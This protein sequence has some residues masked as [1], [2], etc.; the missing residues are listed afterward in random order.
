MFIAYQY[1]EDGIKILTN[2]LCEYGSQLCLDVSA[3]SHPAHTTLP[4]ATTC[5]VLAFVISAINQSLW[6]GVAIRSVFTH[7]VLRLSRE[8]DVYLYLC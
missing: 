1:I 2:N 5:A 7:P 3:V 4:H 8:K 6:T